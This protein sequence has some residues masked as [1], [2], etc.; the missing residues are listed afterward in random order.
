MLEDN[1]TTHWVG[2][3]EGRC[4]EVGYSR[5]WIVDVKVVSRAGLKGAENCAAIGPTALGA[6]K[7]L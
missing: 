6:P 3:L 7:K 1:E 2:T 5:A 4:L